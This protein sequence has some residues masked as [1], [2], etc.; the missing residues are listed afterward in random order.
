MTMKKQETSTPKKRGRPP[1]ASKA[2]AAATQMNLEDLNDA[3]GAEIIKQEVSNTDSIRKRGKAAA[4][5]AAQE[6][7]D[8]AALAQLSASHIQDCSPEWQQF[9]MAIRSAVKI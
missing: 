9:F 1:G 7:A 5:I 3:S 8:T 6:A 2:V 4:A